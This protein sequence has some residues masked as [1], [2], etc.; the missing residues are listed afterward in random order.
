[1]AEDTRPEVMPAGAM[2]P[3]VA[4]IVEPE[5]E[6]ILGKFKTQDDL[7]TAYS[8]LEKKFG[9]Q[10]ND[11]GSQKQMNTML[12]EQAQAR[13]AQDQTPAKVEEVDTFDYE[14]QMGTLQAAVEEG[15]IPIEKALVQASNL[16]AEN[17]T[18][19]ALSKYQEMTAADQQQTAQQ[20]FLD[21]NP[22]F[23]ELQQTGQLEPIKKALPG[24]HDDFSA[25]YALKAQQAATAAEEKQEVSRIAEGD[26]R[27]EKVFVAAELDRVTDE[28]LVELGELR[29]I[30]QNRRHLI[31][32]DGRVG[33]VYGHSQV[34][35]SVV[36]GFVQWNGLQP[37]APRAHPRVFQQVLDQ[38]PH[39]PGPV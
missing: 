2:P 13:Q 14:A 17:A 36:D 29:L 37:P 26:K 33:L 20:S 16:A 9:E 18:R 1:M 27:T 8:E 23:L 21:S 32:G 34:R 19:T 31:A 39:S 3:E 28:V 4:P 5:P 10:G 35:Q 7:A 15:E 30:A 38:P 12:M 25:F 6:P 11:L 22:D 24:M